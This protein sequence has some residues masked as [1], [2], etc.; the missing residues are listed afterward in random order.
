MFG[1]LEIALG[2]HRVAGGL[3]VARE[4]QVFLGH[5]MGRAP[6]LY[7]RPV[8]FIGPGKRIWPLAITTTPPAL[9]L[10]RPRIRLF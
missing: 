8:G 3:G 9:L 6:D 4:L 10:L 2:H 5:V 7:V 1:V